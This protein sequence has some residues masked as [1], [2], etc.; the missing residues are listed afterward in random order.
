MFETAYLITGSCATTT[1]LCGITF[2]NGVQQRGDSLNSYQDK[3]EYECE[4]LDA[5]SA[6]LQLPVKLYAPRIA[7][8][9]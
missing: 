6:L 3:C 1:V 7:K 2:P 4:N 9:I 8:D 5:Y